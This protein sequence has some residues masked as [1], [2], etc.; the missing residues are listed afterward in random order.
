M[1]VVFEV[2]QNARRRRVLRYLDDEGPTTIGD[3]A[4]HIAALENGIEE[5]AVSSD[6]RKLVYVSLYQSHLER[7]HDAGC[8]SY[9]KDRGTVEPGR[10]LD[11]YLSI[12][13]GFAHTDADQLP[14]RGLYSLSASLLLGILLTIVIFPFQNWF[15]DLY[16]TAATIGT[17]IGA[18]VLIGLSLRD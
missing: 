6:Q 13:H 12:M 18:L 5:R 15:P 11:E 3:I 9:D 14:R 16:V 1:D 10:E 7:L 2:L 4:T 17:A 8:I